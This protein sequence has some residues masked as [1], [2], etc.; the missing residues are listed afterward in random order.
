MMYD[1]MP[2]EGMHG[3]EGKVLLRMMACDE[4]QK[5]EKLRHN[6]TNFNFSPRRH[7]GS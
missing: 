3:V 2:K 4:D 7:C 1:E 6:K 5:E